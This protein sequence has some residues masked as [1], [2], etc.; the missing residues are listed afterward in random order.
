M[1][2]VAVPPPPLPPLH[3]LPMAA[4]EGGQERAA[5]AS[6]WPLPG[7]STAWSVKMGNSRRLRR[8][9]ERNGGD[10]RKKRREAE[11]EKKSKG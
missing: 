6:S 5:V 7:S 10:G 11:T 3:M 1:F 4:V 2:S 9:R 8:D